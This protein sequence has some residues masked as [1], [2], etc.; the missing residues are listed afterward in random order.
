V[1]KLTC[2]LDL[3]GVLADFTAGAISLHKL[4]VTHK[5]VDCWD[6]HHKLG[7]QGD[8]E[9]KFW[10]PMGFD[11]WANLPKTREHDAVL[12]I[13]EEVFGDKVVIATSPA[14]TPG[15]V[16]GK[17]A[18]INKHLP[19]Y[20]RRF[21]V[22]ASKHLMASYGKILIDDYEV[23]TKRFFEHGGTAILFPRL[24]NSRGHLTVDGHFDKM[25]TF[26]MWLKDAVRYHN[27]FGDA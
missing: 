24:Y 13:V 8:N 22:G 2:Y 7:F 18:W 11:F 20:S 21:V 12:S 4:P 15:C 1:T 23:N 17:I 27:F 5:D 19:A 25:D 3:D 6:F 26:H 14:S 16:E 10:E 9:K